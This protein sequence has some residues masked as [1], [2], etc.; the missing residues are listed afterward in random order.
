MA[1]V[2]SARDGASASHRTAAALWDCPGFPGTVIEITTTRSLQRVGV[3]VHRSIRLPR[4]Y[5]RVRHGI[6]TTDPERTLVDLGA[7]SRRDAVETALDHFLSNRLT[8]TDRLVQRL[9]ELDG[10]GWRGTKTLGALLRQRGDLEAAESK[11]ETKLF[12]VLRAAGLPPPQRQFE[13]R[14]GG[15][16]VARVDLAYPEARLVLEAQSYRFHSSRQAWTNDV[17]RRRHLQ[18]LGWRVVEVT[19]HDVTKGR[20]EFLRSLRGLLHELSLFE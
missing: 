9:T 2:L 19:W 1:A 12:Q 13:V 16:L 11:L 6:P 5:L 14:D 17:H 18:V 10:P 20:R 8:T 15:Q 7:V 3:T 4:R